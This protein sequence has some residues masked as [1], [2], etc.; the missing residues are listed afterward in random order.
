MLKQKRLYENQR[1][2]LYNQQ[3]NIEQASFAVQ[4]MQDSVHTVQ[5]MAVRVYWARR[6]ARGVVLAC[7][8]CVC[9]DVLADTPV[10]GVGAFVRLVMPSAP[11]NRPRDPAGRRR[12][13]AVQESPH[14]RGSRTHLA[15]S[16]PPSRPCPQA[17]GK[18]LKQVMKHKDLRIENIES[19][20]DSMQDLLVRGRGKWEGTWGL[21]ASQ[22]VAQTVLWGELRSPR[23]S[24]PPPFL[25][26]VV[27]QDMQN[28][29]TE[30]LGASYATPDDIDEAE[31]MGE[32]DALEDE[33]VADTEGGQGLPAYLQEPDLPAAPTAQAA[34]AQPADDFGLPA[35]PAVPQRS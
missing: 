8:V 29:I 22:A 33:L 13:A 3:Y 5:A 16:A 9:V 12:S 11:G 21:R 28:D 4:S 30:A 35:V 19:M 1:D 31:L 2:Q 14:A 23:F 6:R 17:A 25:G 18:E 15:R 26:L 27:V 34:E 32:L 7:C 10:L 20:Q 24:I